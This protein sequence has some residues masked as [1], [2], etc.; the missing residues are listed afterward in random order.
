[1]EK[2]KANTKNKFDQTTFKM[3]NIDDITDSD[4]DCHLDNQLINNVNPKVIEPVLPSTSKSYT[5]KQITACDN[6]ERCVCRD[7]NN[8]HKEIGNHIFTF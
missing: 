2:A 4:D 6:C 8:L 3:F 5:G 1:M 7:W